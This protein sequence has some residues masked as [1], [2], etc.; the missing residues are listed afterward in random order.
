[1]L[2]QAQT[3]CLTKFFLR[4]A[5]EPYLKKLVLDNTLS[6]KNFS[7]VLIDL[8]HF[9]KFN[10]KYGHIFGDEIL[11]YTSGT[12]RLTFGEHQCCLFRYGGDEFIA[13]FTDKEAKEIYHILRHCNY[14]LIHRPFLFKNKLYKITIS[15]G[16]AAFPHDGKTAEELIK[17]ADEAM[18]FSKRHGRNL[19]TSASRIKYLK[20]RSFFL[21]I[22]SI[23]VIFWA[24]FVFYQLTFK[25]VIQPT[26]FQFKNLKF[27]ATPESLLDTIILKNGSVVKGRISEETE[28]RVII[29]LYFNN[30]E[31]ETAFYKSEIED[32][33]YSSPIPIKKH[34][35]I[36]AQK[37]K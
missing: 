23:M 9:K 34:Y 15:C 18:Y 3:D 22:C 26:I 2:E 13:V 37:A 36:P 25:K 14:N 11:K 5:L 30:G 21:L 16:I 28:D 12:L 10:D 32:I 6:K 17:R 19:I 7:I 29:T 27:T 35:K 33:K 20:L 24:L 8:D 1:M 4:E 31:A